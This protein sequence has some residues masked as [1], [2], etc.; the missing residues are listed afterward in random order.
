MT[1][2]DQ[3]QHLGGTVGAQQQAHIVGVDPAVGQGPVAQPLQ[4]AVPLP[5][6]S[7]RRITG[8]SRIVRVWISVSASNSSSSVPKPPGQ[9]TKAHA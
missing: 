3:L 1:L 9:M 8:K 4:Q 6:P 7:P 5:R 2:L